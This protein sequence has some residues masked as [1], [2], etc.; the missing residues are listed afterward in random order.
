MSAACAGAVALVVAQP[1]ASHPA[2]QT[3][4]PTVRRSRADDIALPRGAIVGL[5]GVGVKKEPLRALEVGQDLVGAARY[6]AGA[7]LGAQLGGRLRA[8]FDALEEH[9]AG[10][11]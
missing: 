7:Q 8:A 9:L 5:F 10:V 1:P 6:Q 2:T 3:T 4:T 11:G